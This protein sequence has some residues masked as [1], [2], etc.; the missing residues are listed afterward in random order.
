MTSKLSLLLLLFAFYCQTNFAKARIPIPYG[1]EEKIIKLVDLPDTDDF[2]LDDGSYFDI[3]SMYTKSH[4]LYLS[5][6]NTEPILVGYVNEGESYVD[7]TAEQLAEIGKIANVEIPTEVSVSFF[8]KILGKL[9]LGILGLI[10]IY[11]IYSSYFSK[12]KDREE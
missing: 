5:Y 8:D 1:E 9:I 3:G 10:I 6:S 4:L 2:K 7:L 12:N 11:G